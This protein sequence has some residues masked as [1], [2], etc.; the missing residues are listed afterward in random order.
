MLAII[1][2]VG[3]L[4]AIYSVGYMHDD[5]GY[6]RFFALVS[7][8][9]FSMSMLVAASNFLIVY[10]FWEAVGACSYLLI[11]FWFRKPEA[12]RAA[13]KAFLVNRVGDF[14]LA[15]AT[16]LLWMTYGTLDF[17]DTLSPDGTILPGILGQTRLADAADHR[18]RLTHV[19]D[20]AVGARADEDLVDAD[21]GDGLVGLQAHVDQRALDRATLGVV[22]LLVGVWHALVNGQHHLGTGTPGDLGLELGCVDLD[23]QVEMRTLVA[24]KAT[25]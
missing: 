14:G 6:P 7:M 13:K 1:T 9:V 19:L 15:I 23:H 2:C 20:P 16:F 8:F 11:G 24:A 3:L 17:H 5:P 10:V 22:A 4:V 18:R 25:P 21:V 12:A